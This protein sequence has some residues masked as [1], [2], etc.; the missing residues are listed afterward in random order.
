VLKLSNRSNHDRA[1]QRL[2]MSLLL[3]TLTSGGLAACGYK[4]AAPPSDTDR[5]VLKEATVQYIGIEGGC[6][7]L[8]AQGASYEPAELPKAFRVNGMQVSA[9]VRLRPDLASVCQAGKVVDIVSLA[10]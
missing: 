6:W 4:A 5:V 3:A 7:I 8:R 2:L 1:M 9:T 10:R